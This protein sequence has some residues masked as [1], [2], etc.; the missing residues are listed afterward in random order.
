MDRLLEITLGALQSCPLPYKLLGPCD[1]GRDVHLSWRLDR[2]GEWPMSHLRQRVTTD[3][4]W[5]MD[6]CQGSSEIDARACGAEHGGFGEQEEPQAFIFVAGTSRI[7]SNR[8]V[9]Q[10]P[11]AWKGV[12][13]ESR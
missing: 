7:L 3:V 11:A 1:L 5:A 13:K 9:A 8:D 12:Q 6:I 2:R 4:D 10:H